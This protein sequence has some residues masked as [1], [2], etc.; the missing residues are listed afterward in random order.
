MEI[1]IPHRYNPR[2]YQLPF[3]KAMDSG[4]TRA[5]IVWHRRS[6]KDKT[7]FNHMVKKAMQRVGTYFYLL[8]SYAQ[9]EKVIWD[10]I[11]NDGLKML[12]HIP[13][14]LIAGTN[15][16]KL[17]VDLINGSVIQLIAAD[18][19]EKSVVGTNPIG[20]VFSEYSLTNP[21]AW[22]FL[23][24][25]LAANGGWAIFNFTPRGMNHA[26]NLLQMAKEQPEI[27][28][29]QILTVD[30]TN[31]F[32]KEQIDLERKQHPQD[33]IDQ[34][35][36]CKFIDGAGSF[37]RRVDD[38][39][40]E[41]DEIPNKTSIYRMGVDLAKY[42]DYT[43][44]TLVDITT[45]EVVKQ[46]RFN[47]IDYNLQKAKITSYYYKYF[48]PRVYIDSTGVGEPIYDDLAKAGLDIQPVHFTEAIRKDLLT[49]LQL[50]L[51]QGM[52]K[53]P[54][55]PVLIG[56]LKSFKYI[57]TDTGRVK[58]AVPENLHDDTVFSLA[59]ACHEMPS[60]PVRKV[61]SI[62]NLTTDAYGQTGG[63]S[64]YY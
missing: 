10:N 13:K 7:C 49:N 46:D 24:P 6:G 27:W 55:D 31:V 56:E 63:T 19:F 26:W 15:K 45:F 14:E 5:V 32:T 30:D 47:Q 21:N 12:D 16:T 60:L 42:N 29:W 51:E 50:R 1:T 25:I 18:E 9:A 20:V 17:K 53:I 40:R 2:Q 23:S 58:I 64:D 22:K 35:Y 38:N 36:Y 52:I 8:P 39:V 28:W 11:D 57:L 37:F 54:N 34:E 43:V 3:L 41:V 59:L 48:K 4:K 44:I 62:R 61:Q 33:F